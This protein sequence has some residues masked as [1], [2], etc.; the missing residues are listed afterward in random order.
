MQTNTQP[1]PCPIA[2]T[3]SRFVVLAAVLL[4]LAGCAT[5]RKVNPAS[6]GTGAA[7]AGGTAVDKGHSVVR[8]ADGREGFIISETPRLDAEARSE[9]ERAAAM[10]ES[11]EYDQAIALLAKVIEREPGVAAPYIDIAM[12]YAQLNKPDQ[13][14]QHLQAALNLVPDHPVASNEYG[15]L[16]RKTG[17]FVEARTVYE[18]SLAAFPEYLPVRR[19]LGILCDLYLNDLQ[20]ALEQYE[21]LGQVMPE[22]EQVKLW[23]ADLNL[24]LGH[25]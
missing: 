24:R 17:R 2:R 5:G 22:D 13:A 4:V 20:C 18:K 1:L 10:L 16:L 3:W 11:R 21:I 14:E 25:Q 19:N 9:F 12:A 6:A 8:L 15:L 7:A 23:I